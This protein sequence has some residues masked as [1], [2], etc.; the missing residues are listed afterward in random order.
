MFFFQQQSKNLDSQY[1]VSLSKQH[2]D[3]NLVSLLSHYC[4]S[5]YFH[6]VTSLISS[7]AT[8][9][10]IYFLINII[11][12]FFFHLQVFF[13]FFGQQGP[14]GPPGPKGARGG[15]GS[16]VSIPIIV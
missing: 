8:E 9:F 14:S 11:L 2:L 3:G 4:P 6:K 7:A 16:P 5:S 15:A 12:C 13:V 1:A 10:S